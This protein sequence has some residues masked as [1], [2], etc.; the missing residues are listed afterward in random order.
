MEVSLGYG[1]P[2][3]WTIITAI[4]NET[5]EVCSNEYHPRIGLDCC[6]FSTK[7]GKLGKLIWFFLPI[8]I[9]LI[10]NVIF[11]LKIV[12]KIW[13]VDNLRNKILNRAGRNDDADRYKYLLESLYRY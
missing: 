4:V 8:A 2:L 3:A 9:C 5:V 10:L 13:S 12:H 1:L 7:Y 6:F 11:F